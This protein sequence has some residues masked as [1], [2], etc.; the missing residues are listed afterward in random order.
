MICAGSSMRAEKYRGSAAEISA[1]E[2][3]SYHRPALSFATGHAIL[4]LYIQGFGLSY[5]YSLQ[6]SAE[7]RLSPPPRK[8]GPFL[9]YL[10]LIPIPILSYIPYLYVMCLAI[11]KFGRE[12]AKDQKG[13]EGNNKDPVRKRK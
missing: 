13:K 1:P 5:H 7:A 4:P 3:R 2:R 12:E 11:K 10:L 6:N 9:F 8:N